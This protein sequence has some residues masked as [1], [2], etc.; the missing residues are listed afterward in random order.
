MTNLIV[1]ALALMVLWSFSSPLSASA[2]LTKLR[3]AYLRRKLVVAGDVCRV[4]RRLLREIWS[5]RRFGFDSQ[6]GY[7]HVR[8]DRRRNTDDPTRRQRDDPGCLARRGDT[9]NVLTLVSIIPQSL[10]VAD[11]KTPEDLKGKRFGVSRF[12]A[13]SDLVIRRYLR[14][15]GLD[16]A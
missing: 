10:V 9:V 1:R 5:G 13:L 7:D 11:I 12:G 8:A 15:F 2:Q 16:P 4:R 3:G 6:R 14:K